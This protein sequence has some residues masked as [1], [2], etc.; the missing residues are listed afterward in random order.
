MTHLILLLVCAAPPPASPSIKGKHAYKLHEAVIL[1]VAPLP[2]GAKTLHDLY[3]DHDGCWCLAREGDTRRCEGEVSV[4]APAG[5]YRLRVDVFWTGD[6]GEIAVARVEHYFVIGNGP[7]PTPLPTDKVT[8]P[9]V[10]GKWGTTAGPILAKAGLVAAYQGDSKRTVIG[11]SPAAGAAV[12]TGSTVTLT[13]KSDAPPPPP[14]YP[15]A[16][17]PEPGF[18][19]LIVYES[20]QLRTMPAAQ[21]TILFSVPFRKYLDSVCADDAQTGSKKGWW[22]LDQHADVSGLAKLW[23]DAMKRPRASVPWIQIS[24]GDAN[25]GFEGPLPAD[26]AATQALIGRYVGVKGKKR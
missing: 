16:P 14:D 22:M 4:W 13:M 19:V 1:E 11:Q 7:T 6:K 15:P 3:V 23:Q 18:R 5:S 20:A 2:K 17:I 21:Q 12:A 24:N 10:V 25:V 9:D 26:V 8:V